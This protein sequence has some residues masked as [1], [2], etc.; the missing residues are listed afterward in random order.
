MYHRSV[1]LS[2]LRAIPLRHWLLAVAGG[3]VIAGVVM[4]VIWTG[5]HGWAVYQ[6]NRG[7]GDTTF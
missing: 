4:T 5:R 7:V 2:D 1:R 3:I 6:L